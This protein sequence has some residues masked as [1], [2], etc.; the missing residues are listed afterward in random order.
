[1]RREGDDWRGQQKRREK[2]H[3]LHSARPSPRLRQDPIAKRPAVALKPQDQQGTDDRAEDGERHRPPS[4][5]GISSPNFGHPRGLT[6][7]LHRPA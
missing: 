6:L 3:E 7:A 1:M 5:S 4:H 2:T